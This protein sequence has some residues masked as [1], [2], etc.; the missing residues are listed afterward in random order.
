MN[1]VTEMKGVIP[2]TLSRSGWNTS[3]RCRNSNK[4]ASI[5]GL[6]VLLMSRRLSKLSSSC[7]FIWIKFKSL[8]RKVILDAQKK[9]PYSIRFGIGG[10]F[11]LFSDP[12][13][14]LG[15]VK[16]VVFARVHG[17]QICG[18]FPRIRGGWHDLL[19]FVFA[20]LIVEIQ[21]VVADSPRSRDVGLELVVLELETA[22]K[23]R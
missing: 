23:A 11:F 8:I 7:R 18:L 14:D 5:N 12:L 19:F 6:M 17:V 15:F 21:I 16:V 4:K 1:A 3:N 10:R 13:S 2:D 9:T 20:V 22:F